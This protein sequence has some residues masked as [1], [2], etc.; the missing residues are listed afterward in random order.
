MSSNQIEPATRISRSASIL[1]NAS[2]DLVFPLFTPL[3]EKKWVPGW[4]PCIIY[5]E[6]HQLEEGLIF[7][8][9]GRFPGESFYTWVLQTYDVQIHLAKY[10]V[11][12]SDRIWFITV[13]CREQAL[14]KT[15][16]TITYTF[17]SLTDLGKSLN[18][19]AL[20]M[21]FEENLLDW[22]KA[23]NHFLETGQLIT[24]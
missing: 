7:Q 19:K 2:I 23:L 9:P 17:T 20:D 14:T 15:E 18:E 8:T 11:F 1:L 22:E 4:N 5:P 16:A 21:M 24:F 3:G 12:T 10:T 13:Q 6:P